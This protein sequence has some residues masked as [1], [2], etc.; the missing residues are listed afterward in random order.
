MAVITAAYKITVNSAT[1]LRS[2]GG[3]TICGGGG[4][5]EDGGGGTTPTPWKEGG[6]GGTGG[7]TTDG[8]GGMAEGAAKHSIQRSIMNNEVQPLALQSSNVID[9]ISCT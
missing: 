2:A 4:T 5:I 9:E 1:W 7:I 8:G 3:G 6:G